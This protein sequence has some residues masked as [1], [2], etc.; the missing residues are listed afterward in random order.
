M[1]VV[2]PDVKHLEQVTKYDCWHAS[3]RMMVKWRSGEATEPTGTHTDWLYKQCRL[4]QGDHN[5]TKKDEAAKL[6]ES[7]GE[8]F[9]PDIIN[10]HAAKTADI[11]VK[12]WSRTR[13]LSPRDRVEGPFKPFKD[14]PGLTVPLVPTILSENGLRSVRGTV[15][16]EELD[17]TSEAVGTM[18]GDHGPLYLLLNWGHVVVVT[19]IEN[20]TLTVSDPLMSASSELSLNLLAM[21]PCVARLA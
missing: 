9:G 1:V 18:L 19:G 2:A 16:T 8:K 17:A 6:Q 5:I 20:D 13:A 10:H 21:S 11:A 7:S 15:V 4:A 3:L 12:N 14:R